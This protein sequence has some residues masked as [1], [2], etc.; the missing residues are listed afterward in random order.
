MKRGSPLPL[1]GGEFDN[2]LFKVNL[3]LKKTYQS[4]N[5]LLSSYEALLMIPIVSGENNLPRGCKCL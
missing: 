2:F 4:L 3:P 1:G 5:L